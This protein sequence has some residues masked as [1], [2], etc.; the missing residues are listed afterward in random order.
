MQ[1]AAPLDSSGWICK[2]DETPDR[3]T[4]EQSRAM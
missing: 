1:G 4:S 2:Q 3:K